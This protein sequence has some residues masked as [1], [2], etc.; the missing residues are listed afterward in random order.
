MRDSLA[1]PKA[2]TLREVARAAGVSIAT[3]SKVVNGRFEG[4]TP[5]TRERVEEAVR[6]L[7]YRPNRAGR[8]LRSALQSRIGALVVD[9]SPR[10]LADPFITNLVAGVSNELSVRGY[11]LLLSRIDPAE[12]ESSYIMKGQEADALAV[13][14]SGAGDQRR[15]L[16]G[17][18]AGLRHPMV[19]FQE[20]VT[21][22]LEDVC[23]VRQ[24]DRDGARQLARRILER[25]ARQVLCLTP[26]RL[27]PAIEERVAGFEE[28]LVPAG[29]GVEVLSCDEDDSSAVG[30][31]LE[32]RLTRGPLPDVVIGGND[33]LAIVALELLQARGLRVPEDVGVIGFNA[34][35][36]TI[37]VHPRLTTARS[38][39]Y[40]L[41]E[42]GARMLLQRI[43]QGSFPTRETV[44]PVEMVEGGSL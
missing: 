30:G 41:G 23:S 34:F 27:W 4:M 25:G 21:P 26:G 44:L 8:S 10:F 11:G 12:P 5:S 19:I 7:N 18:L 9:P 3:V 39:A 32:G 33:R 37:A 40:E 1:P 20:E 28:V 36:F 15:R 2:A 38:P 31:C 17:Q 43:E 35:P 24:D 14:L 6:N 13:L 22:E 29:V 16:L 42:L